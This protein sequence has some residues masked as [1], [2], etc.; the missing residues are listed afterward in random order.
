[1]QLTKWGMMRVAYVVSMFPCWSETFI[2][3]ELVNHQQA[4]VDLSIFSIKNCSETMVHD[5]AVPFIDKTVYGKG[6][7]NIKLMLS[8]LFL[9]FISPFTYCHVISKLLFLKAT[10]PLVKIKTLAVFW[11]SPTF[12]LASKQKQ[13]E[14][15]HA[16]FATYPALLAWII[17]RFTKIPYTFTAHAHDIY[18]NQDLLQLVC[19]DAARIVTISE[20]NKNF[21]AQKVGTKYEEKTE[22]IHC[23]IDLQRF[24][25]EVEKVYTGSNDSPLNILSIGRLSGI[26]GFS[27]LIEALRLLR[28]D[29]I[30]FDCSIIGDGHLKPVLVKQVKDAGLEDVVY[31]LGSKK[32]DEIPAYLKKADVFVLACATDKIEGHDGIPVVFMESMAYGTPVIGTVISGIPELIKNFE[33]GLCSKPENPTDLKDKFKYFISNP[34]KVNHMRIA[35]RKLVEKEYDINKTC[36]NLRELFA[37]IHNCTSN[38]LIR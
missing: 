3:N 19:E 9:F 30:A 32:A 13:T 20:F 36:I 37:K 10:D 17:S 27:Y 33:T 25:F 21:I 8:H 4:G 23:G 26:K 6:Y 11:L 5:E 24:K 38:I 35:A 12:V 16:H 18:V 28:E 31:F 7:F 14:H 22:V 29:G 15:L 2:L 34:T 1:M